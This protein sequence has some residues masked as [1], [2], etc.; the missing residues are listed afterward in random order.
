MA[1]LSNPVLQGLLGG[2]GPN[3]IRARAEQQAAAM[4]PRGGGGMMGAPSPIVVRDNSGAEIGQGLAGLGQGI[5]A[6]GQARQAAKQKEAEDAAINQ[7]VDSIQDPAQ[8]K[9]VMAL[10]A[11][12]QGRQLLMGALAKQAF[13]T[14]GEGFTLGEGQT[15]F[16]AS[17]KPVASGPA[18][19]D[20]FKLYGS[21]KTG[22]YTIETG[23]DGKPSVNMMISPAGREPTSLQQDYEY[24]KKQFN[25]GMGPDPGSFTQFVSSTRA[26][27]EKAPTGYQ[28][29]PDGSLTYIPGGPA[30]PNAP[31]PMTEGQTVSATFADRM[32]NA[33]ETI[34]KFEEVGTSRFESG[35]AEVPVIGN[36]LATPEYRQLEQAQRSFLNAVLRKE[37]GAVISQS[38]FDIGARQYFP[39]PGDDQETLA[40]KA[41]ERRIAIEGMQRAAGPSYKP[42]KPYAGG[43]VGEPGSKDNPLRGVTPEESQKLPKGTYYIGVDRQSRVV[44]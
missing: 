15:R 36:Y 19:K 4:T 35:K 12:P 5:A 29:G 22:Y 20:A 38:E 13:P 40:R 1:L 7:Y 39:Q 21:D 24:A 33:N 42:P 3:A 16:D 44:E 23:A 34:S 11:M 31:K 9:Q 10:A 25:D 14:P 30:D 26:T 43:V 8:R 32:V 2:G 27:I 28:K 17:G 41:K 18:K 6:L 37:S